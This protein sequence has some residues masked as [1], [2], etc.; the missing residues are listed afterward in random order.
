[1]LNGTVHKENFQELYKRMR[2]VKNI[3][4]PMPIT[5]ETVQIPLQGGVGIQKSRIFALLNI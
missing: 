4:T 5:K 2:G 3:V 1:M